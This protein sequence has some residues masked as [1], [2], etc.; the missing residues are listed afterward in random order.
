[1]L[2][3]FYHMILKLIKNLIF[4]MKTPIFKHLLRNVIID[5]II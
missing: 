5:V 1:M 3:S 2:D 4:G